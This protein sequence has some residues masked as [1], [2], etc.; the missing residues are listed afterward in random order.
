MAAKEDVVRAL[1]LLTGF[2]T[3]VEKEK[4]KLPYEKREMT[5]EEQKNFL[6]Q[7]CSEWCKKMD[8]LKEEERRN[9]SS[10][11]ELYVVD[12]FFGWK[13][14]AGYIPMIVYNDYTASEFTSI[15]LYHEYPREELSDSIVLVSKIILRLYNQEEDCSY[16]FEGYRIPVPEFFL[17]PK[18]CD[19]FI[20]EY[21]GYQNKFPGYLRNAMLEETVYRDN[22]RYHDDLDH[23]ERMF[24]RER[25]DNDL[26]VRMTEDR[27][28]MKGEYADIYTS[29]KFINRPIEDERYDFREDGVSGIIPK[30]F[31]SQ[32]E[33]GV[34]YVANTDNIWLDCE[35]EIVDHRNVVL[36]VS[37]SFKARYGY[38]RDRQ[39]WSSP[40][41][42]TDSPS[43]ENTFTV[44]EVTIAD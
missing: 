23:L 10:W 28:K 25:E 13:V 18:Y 9:L 42:L 20:G 11:L 14:L 16:A 6:N 30:F 24:F 15:P 43:N 33:N 38:K 31:Q 27:D 17:F 39:A 21:V 5:Q 35:E 34:S 19:F 8:S 1:G 22:P 7:Y 29:V 3:E 36:G 44:G 37:E 41:Y 2:R 4:E 32:R 12:D 26:V 40:A